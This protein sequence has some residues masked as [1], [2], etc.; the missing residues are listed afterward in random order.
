[1]D[2]EI[3]YN[4]E[5][6]ESAEIAEKVKIDIE[7]LLAKYKNTNFIYLGKEIAFKI[8]RIYKVIRY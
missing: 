7:N 1:M 4:P 2:I 6:G 3:T 5:E 8:V